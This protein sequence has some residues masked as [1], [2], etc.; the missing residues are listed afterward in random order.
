MQNVTPSY[1]QME[2]DDKLRCPKCNSTQV[3]VDKKGVSFGKACCG[4]LACGPFGML[5]GLFGANKLRRTC[6]KC[7]YTWK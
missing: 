7:D 5:F 2:D 4:R 3:H 1:N 6:L